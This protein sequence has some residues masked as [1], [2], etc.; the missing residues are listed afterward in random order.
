MNE[1]EERPDSQNPQQKARRM[2]MPAFVGAGLWTLSAKIVSQLAQLLAFLLA[3]RILESA[4]FGF[5]AYSSA[6]AILLVLCAEG[7]WGEYVMKSHSTG[8]EL[9]QIGTIA[10]MSGVLCTGVG[11]LISGALHVWNEQWL[12]ILIAL[13][14]C[15]FL[16]SSLSVVYDGLLVNR[17]QLKQQSIIRIVAEGLGLAV[18]IAGL[19]AGF[20]VASLIIGRL[21][22][23]T[24]CLVGSFIVVRWYPRFHLTRAFLFDILEFSRHILSNRIIFYLRSYSGTLALGSFL[25]LAEAGYYRAAERIVGAISELLG[26]PARMLAWT[27]FRKIK[28]QPADPQKFEELGRTATHFMTALMIVSAPV[29]IGL[30]L[31]SPALVDIALG[32]SWAPTAALVSILAIKQVLLIPG[33]VTEPLLSITGN[34]ARMPRLML[35]NGVVAIA[36]IVAAAPFGVEAAAFGQCIAALISLKISAHLQGRYGGLD[37]KRVFRDC[38]YVFIAILAM[39]AIVYAFGYIGEAT[40]M[41]RIEMIAFQVLSGAVTYFAALGVMHRFHGGVVPIWEV[42]DQHKT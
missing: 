6:I 21:V 17:G 38:G 39:S 22:M 33:Y 29:Y 2:K 35:L 13:Y 1:R 3:A 36:L 11:F 24:T 31:V 25:G 41:T 9:D 4:Q 10:V 32:D 27:A 7:G 20:H 8:R 34:I 30:A 14:S 19:H 37:W 12:G 40:A 15:W 26:E 42:K 18:T 16:P 5:Y 23:Q 28:G